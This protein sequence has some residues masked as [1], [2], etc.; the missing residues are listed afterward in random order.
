MMKL[1][2]LRGKMG[3]K[4]NLKAHTS[5]VILL[6]VSIII[7][8]LFFIFGN[9]L[10]ENTEKVLPYKYL[11]ILAF[12]FLMISLIIL[13]YLIFYRNENK[14]LN[15]KTPKKEIEKK[16][17]KRGK[18][19]LSSLSLEEK[20]ILKQYINK[21]TKTQYFDISNGVISNLVTMDIIFRASITSK[22]GFFFAYNIQPWAWNCLNENKKILD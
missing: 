11:L 15:K 21:G 22:K 14:E 20:K 12:I 5:A 16:I 2:L 17:I 3:L 8:A 7:S 19:Y 1:G 4:E 6:I 9:N 10:I 18:K 13:S